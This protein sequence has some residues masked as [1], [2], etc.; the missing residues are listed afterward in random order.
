MIRQSKAN[1][2]LAL[3]V[4]TYYRVYLKKHDSNKNVSKVI[5]HKSKLMHLK[6]MQ[7]D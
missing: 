5:I 6:F 1:D 3:E 7:K 2:E 4:S